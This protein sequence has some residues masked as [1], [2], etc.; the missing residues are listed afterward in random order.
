MS[1]PMKKRSVGRPPKVDKE[2]EA[3]KE[4]LENGF[5]CLL[6][7]TLKTK[8][9]FYVNTH[10]MCKSGVT[11]VCKECARKIACR[12]DKYGDE[13]EPTEES[14]IEALKWLNK[15]FIQ[16]VWAASIQESENLLA[17]KVRHNVWFSYVKNIAMGQ[18]NGM[19]FQ[20]SDI[21]KERI[22]YNDEMNEEEQVEYHNGQDTYDSFLKNRADVVRLLDYDPFEKESVS[23][24]PFLY[25]QLLGLLDSNGEGND[26]MMR[27]SSCISIV[28]GF[29]QSTKIDD[30][31]AK[32]MSDVSNLERNS[33][34]IKSL[35]ESKLKITS[36]IK[37]LAAESC[38][39][40]AHTKHSLKGENTWTGKIKKIK[41]LNLRE[42]QV[43]GFDIMTCKA[44]RQV[45]DLSDAAI[46]QQLGLDES[47]W[48]DMVAE[49]RTVR[50][51]L[52]NQ[53][54]I[55]KEINRVLLQEN[56]DLKDF[57]EENN[58]Q[59]GK[60]LVNLKEIYSPFSAYDDGKE[61]DD[62]SDNSSE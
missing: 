16:S 10:P 40:L 46:L 31:I 2:A 1:T 51:E 58:I 48:S 56:L 37:D 8:D 21:F 59:T 5:R 13:H 44:M 45:L 27:T 28:R 3:I 38:I 9:K 22:L 23:D 39:S 34:T 25:S 11:P 62:E 4:L 50:V 49:L 7:D 26:D 6:C 41:D 54:E 47:E 30:T 20:D 12:V 52:E 35:Q 14:C 17:G 42:A 43:N 24:Q 33:A 61:G 32:L 29:L 15:P 60:K 18:Y 57:L 19:T 55:Y 53:L 36:M